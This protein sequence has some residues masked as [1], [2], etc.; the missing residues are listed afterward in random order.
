MLKKFTLSAVVASIL[1]TTGSAAM[2]APKQTVR[3]PTTIQQQIPANVYLSFGAV[4][5]TGSVTVPSNMKIQNQGFNE[6][7]GN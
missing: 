2:A 5:A 6:S 4:R 7:L 3:H 1:V